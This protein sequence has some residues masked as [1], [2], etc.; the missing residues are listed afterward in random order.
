M[1]Y[2]YVCIYIICINKT[3]LRETK[4]AYENKNHSPTTLPKL[5]IIIN[6]K[7]AGGNIYT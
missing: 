4:Y 5:H 2:I 7:F 3:K 6:N 1:Y